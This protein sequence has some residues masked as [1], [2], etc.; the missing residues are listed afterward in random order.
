MA[1]HGDRPLRGA[2]RITLAGAPRRYENQGAKIECAERGVTVTLPGPETWLEFP[3]SA[4]PEV[5]KRAV[6]IEAA[7]VPESASG[8]VLAHGGDRNGYSLYLKDGRP[9]FS[10]CS[11]WKRKT[12]IAPEK[13]GRDGARL[14]AELRADGRMVL[15]VDDR[16]LAEGK[17]AGL[18]SET[19]GDTLQIGADLVKPVG[20]YDVPNCLRGEIEDLTLTV[21]KPGKGR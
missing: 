4:A 9:A 20:E 7:V 16:T 12:T 18:L 8:V 17:A 2:N 10:V 6:A 19:P 13:L 5:G 21:T 1:G 15:A 3:K 14:R 11:D